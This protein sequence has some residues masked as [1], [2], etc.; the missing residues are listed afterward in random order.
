MKR[1]CLTR[2]RA[3]LGL[4]RQSSPRSAIVREPA[5]AVTDTHALLF[6]AAG[7]SRL[8]ARAKS[9]FAAAE[10][11][12]AI[13][14]VPM[15]VIWEVTLLARGTCQSSSAGAEFLRRSFQ[16]SVVSASCP[17]RVADL[18]GWGVA[19]AARS[20]RCVDLCRGTRPRLAADHRGRGDH[21]FG[22][23]QDDLVTKTSGAVLKSRVPSPEDHQGFA[24]G[25]F[26]FPFSSSTSPTLF[27]AGSLNT[28]RTTRPGTSRRGN[29][30]VPPRSF[31]LANVAVMSST[32]T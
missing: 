20:V 23:G 25:N 8:G 30:I 24:G 27:P 9:L 15:V 5:S 18:R 13:V 31:T 6:H 1:E 22:A 21:W 29:R 4:R 26:A 2:R 3:R 11:R 19:G 32:P 12:N 7:G 16:Q 17:G 28:A 10:E 14:Y